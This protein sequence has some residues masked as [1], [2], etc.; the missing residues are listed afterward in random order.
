MTPGAIVLCGGQ[1][2]RM[3]RPKLWLPFG[4]EVLLQRVV[5][6]V[7]EVAEPIVVVAAPGQDL[8]D[9]PGGVSVVRDPVTDRGPLQGLAAGLA[10]LPDSVELAYATATDVPFLAPAWVLRLV[11]LIG[12]HDLAIPEVGGYLHPLAALYRPGPVRVA[13]DA[14]LR[15]G[16]LRPVFLLEALR[17]RVV[18][19]PTMAPADGD[20]AT[21]RNLNTPEEYRRA[22]VDAG[23]AGPEADFHAL[24]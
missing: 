11:E 23:F 10:A 12:E 14:L 20:L 1:S 3:G 8:P 6:L 13:V 19:A 16:R 9:L 4:P 18:D 22:L 5:R 24:D 21:L 2:R 17:A 15:D 7:G